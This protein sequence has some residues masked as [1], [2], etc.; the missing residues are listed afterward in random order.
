MEPNKNVVDELSN[1][2]GEQL[3]I[4]LTK[5]LEDGSDLSF[6]SWH[7]LVRLELEQPLVDYLMGPYSNSLRRRGIEPLRVEQAQVIV[8][9]A[10]FEARDI[11]RTLV[12]APERVITAGF[13]VDTLLRRV[14][15][16]KIVSSLISRVRD[17]FGGRA[18]D[19]EIERSGGGEGFTGR[20]MWVVNVASSRHRHLNGEVRDR[21]GLFEVSPGNFWPGPRSD[22][23]AVSQSSN[24]RCSLRFEYLEKDGNVTWR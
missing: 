1:R 2:L 4:R 22:I 21:D 9:R 20:K 6:S 13:F 12:N 19:L 24:C 17:L 7:K 16:G 23:F 8:Q 11:Y 3:S 18:V 15:Q 5:W 10:L 14:H